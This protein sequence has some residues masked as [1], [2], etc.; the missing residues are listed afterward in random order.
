MCYQIN[1]PKRRRED[2]MS[3]KSVLINGV[4]AVIMLMATV[5][6]GQASAQSAADFFKGKSIKF[7]SPQGAGGGGDLITRLT[8][9]YL[10]PLI[11]ASIGVV[12]DTTAAGMSAR[13]SFFR[14]A[15]PDGLTLMGDAAAPA[16]W[17]MEAEGVNFDLS[18]M[19][20]LG[21]VK[22]AESGLVVH[23]DG[24]YNTFEKFKSGKGLKFG[25][26]TA[27]AIPTMS[28]IAV[29]EILGLNDAK[30]VIG[31]PSATARRLALDQKEIDGLA[32]TID[33]A[34][35]DIEKGGK[36]LILLAVSVDRDPNFKNVPAISEFVKLTDYHKKLL[37]AVPLDYKQ[38]FA[39]PG[40]P[41]DRLDYLRANIDKVFLDKGFQQEAGKVQG[42]WQGAMT[43]IEHQ[44]YLDNLSNNKTDYLKTWNQ[45][46]DKFIQK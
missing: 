34:I 11:G 28:N 39:P 31:F 19:Y 20:G 7:I 24:P 18:K 14:T 41:K 12:N 6:G 44:K 4:V 40:I 8:A 42:V 10:A 30:I 32:N 1:I 21:A 46:M 26:T 36:G 43:G 15:K 33:T 16:I 2:I 35:G 3:K 25:A 38:L 45:L 27:S 23:K 9:K 22:C 13:N 5:L 29:L 17:L 37:N